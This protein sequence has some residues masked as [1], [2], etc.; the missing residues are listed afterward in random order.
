M[1]RR[2]Q[3][4][5]SG[6]EPIPGEF[7]YWQNKDSVAAQGLRRILKLV[8]G[9]DPQLPDDVVRQFA[10]SYY[11]ADPVAEAFVEDVYRTRGQA[12]GRALLD[13]AL[14][15]GVDNVS[16]A[17]DS[18]KRL[19]YELEQAP[20]WVDF[21]QVELGARVFRRFGTHMYSQAGA[22]TLEGYR[23]NSVAKP[24]AL[25]GQYSGSTA[26]Q[27]F[28]ETARF[29]IDVSSPGGLAPGGA[30][31][32]TALRVRVMHVFVRQQL[33]A[34]PEWDYKNWGVPISQ[35]DALLT[36]MGGSFVPGYSMRIIGYRTSRDEIEAMMHFWR[37]VGH[38]MGVQPRWYPANI[39]EA[40]GLM[41]TSI[42]KGAHAAG[43]DAVDLAQS[44]IA[45]YRPTDQDSLFDRV[46]K[47]LEYRLQLGYSVIWIPPG[48]RKELK[49][50]NPGIWAL[51]PFLQFP[52]IFALETLRRRIPALDK[53]RDRQARRSAKKWVRK[54]LGKR[55]AEFHAAEQ[56]TR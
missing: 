35:G 44:Y 52:V 7:L 31:R 41:Y 38:L 28:L 1:N 23:E 26:N 21:D 34:H 13:A 39:G 43:D 24:L 42:V 15:Q 9:V 25:T 37:Y 30:G 33:L 47:S 29:W 20:D 18:L 17:P 50:K 5:N 40:L 54:R 46:I 11:D 27:R 45:S 16:D 48:T 53:F 56:F 6:R 51:H 10:R 12:E 3:D 14:E 8:F 4:L 49:L 2:A 55:K 32:A 19:F 22:I 36:L